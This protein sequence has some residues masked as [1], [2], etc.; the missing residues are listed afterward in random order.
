MSGDDTAFVRA[1]AADGTGRRAEHVSGVTS[2]SQ[3][4]RSGDMYPDE[5]PAKVGRDRL[6]APTSA[7]PQVCRRIPDEVQARWRG[8]QG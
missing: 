5:V 7:R 1:P 8:G 2:R 3:A 4:A 6:T